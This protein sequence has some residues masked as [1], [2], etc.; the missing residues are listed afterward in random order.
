V[1]GEVVVDTP[2]GKVACYKKDDCISATIKGGTFW[3][4]P[5][6]LPFYDKFAKQGEVAIDIG[7]FNGISALYL[8]SRC[9]HVIA[10]EPVHWLLV[11]E[12][13]SANKLRNVTLLRGAAYH[14]ACWMLPAPDEMQGQKVNG[15]KPEE[16]DNPGGVALQ[17]ATAVESKEV[18]CIQA[19]VLDKW[20]D[21][22]ERVCLVKSDAQGCDLRALQGMRQTIERCRPAILFE[23][24]E[25]LAK[26]QGDRWGDYQAFFEELDY[27]LEEQDK[28]GYARNYVA[29]PR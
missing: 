17:R 24:E 21:P 26:I 4:G 14:Q 20:L 22:D 5:L 3:D 29:V 6:L 12:T 11:E 1:G 9:K 13:F 10:V 19:V 8:S 18:E 28:I 27:G 25:G 7:S 23:F 16:I 2:Y 15:V